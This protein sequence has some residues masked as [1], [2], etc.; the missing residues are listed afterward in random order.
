V[1]V[2]PRLSLS[3][4]A[5]KAYSIADFELRSFQLLNHAYAR[6]V[7]CVCRAYPMI[8]QISSTTLTAKLVPSRFDSRGE[9]DYIC[10]G[11]KGALS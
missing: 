10:T 4:Q 2:I 1:H 9:V 6:Q 7:P 8:L 5:E 3:G 11:V